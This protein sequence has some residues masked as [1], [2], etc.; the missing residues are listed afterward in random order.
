MQVKGLRIGGWRS[1]A[2]S[3][4][5]IVESYG[6]SVSGLKAIQH[7]FTSS[8]DEAAADVGGGACGGSV[9]VACRPV[10]AVDIRQRTQHVGPTGTRV[11]ALLELSTLNPS[12][13]DLRRTSGTVYVHAASAE[14]NARDPALGRGTTE[15]R[16]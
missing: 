2:E 13:Q 11:C 10:V 14:E 6:F 16:M 15:G 3:S 9:P 4:G 7:T 5:L 12:V 8:G 1:R